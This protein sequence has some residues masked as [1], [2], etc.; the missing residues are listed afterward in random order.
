[1]CVGGTWRKD[2]DIN[3]HPTTGPRLHFSFVP[4]H[5]QVSGM[6]TPS[7]HPQGPQ[8]A[9]PHLVGG[10]GAKWQPCPAQLGQQ[11][12]VNK[13]VVHLG[14]TKQHGCR[15]LQSTPMFPKTMWERPEALLGTSK[16]P[17]VSQD[18]AGKAWGSAGVAAA[19]LSIW[20]ETSSP[21]PEWRNQWLGSIL[22]AART[23]WVTVY[24]AGSFMILLWYLERWLS[25]LGSYYYYMFF[26][27]AFFLGKFFAVL[28]TNEKFYH[29]HL[30]F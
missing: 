5:H 30:Y 25:F 1:M 27:T 9:E 24:G 26:R 29:L 14:D 4:A 6:C 8:G 3:I 18:S 23:I 28:H 16:Y 7:S 20:H 19:G 22:A 10:W 12:Q 13:L 17:H 11:K 21:K 2:P 15:R